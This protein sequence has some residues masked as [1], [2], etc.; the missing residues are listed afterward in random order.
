MSVRYH[1]RTEA[2]Y[3]SGELGTPRAR[4]SLSLSLSLP[5]SL[6]TASEIPVPQL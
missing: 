3:L 1:V 2:T 6:H 5:L 4:L